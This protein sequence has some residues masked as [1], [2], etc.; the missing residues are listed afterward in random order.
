MGNFEELSHGQP[1][2][3]VG[4]ANI[5]YLIEV[6]FI[7]NVKPNQ[8]RLDIARGDRHKKT[9]LASVVSAMNPRSGHV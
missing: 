9:I 5:Y 1:Q 4:E 3:E 2:Q 8:N 7:V 6:L